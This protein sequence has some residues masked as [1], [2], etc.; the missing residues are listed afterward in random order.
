MS[1]EFRPLIEV[2]RELKALALKKASGFLF[3]VTE[4]NHSCIIRINAGQIEEV[5]FRMLRNDEAVQRLTMVGAAKAR[6][7]VDPGAGMGKPSLLSEDSRQW[8]M[9]GFEQDLG[10]APAP[11]RAPVAAAPAPAPATPVATSAPASVGNGAVPD[12]AVRQALERVA[13]NY[14]GPIAGMLCDEAWDASS[15]IEQVLSQL[16]AN[17]ATPQEAQKFMTDA[18]VALAKVR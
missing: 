11:V 5:V 17:L 18:R 10:G 14:L 16:A 6:F 8:L 1:T 2:L 7:Q 13:L 9:G 3:V 12:D 4:E 15:D